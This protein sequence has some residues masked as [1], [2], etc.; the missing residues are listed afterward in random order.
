VAHVESLSEHLMWQAQLTAENEEE[1]FLYES[2]ITSLDPSG[3]YTQEIPDMTGRKSV[4]TDL[5]EQVITK[6]RH[7]DP[8]GCACSNV[9]E[10]LLIQAK[11]YY[12]DDMVM[13]RILSDHFIDLE[14]LN[15]EKIARGIN[16]SVGE[17][18]ETSKMIQNLD[19]FPGRQFR[20]N[21]V[22]YIVPDIDVKYVD[23]EI[24]VAMNDDWIPPIR[25]NSYYV[26]I[27]RKKSIEKNLKDYIQDKLQS[28]K[29]LIK[30]IA[31]RRET[32]IKVVAA[33][34]EA[35]KPFLI[36]GPG[37]L[38]PLTHVEIAEKIGMHESTVSRATTNKFVQTSW[39][40]F[41]LKY[42]FV[43]KLK[44]ANTNEQSSDQVMNLVKNLIDSEDHREPLTD[45]DIVSV[46]KKNGINV[47]R[48]TIS[49]Y[50]S[51]LNIPPSHKRKKI[52]MIKSEGNL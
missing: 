27:L 42:F 3:F 32:I 49:K 18:I 8:V 37:N 15:Y 31:S 33:I 43:S 50:R 34:M 12:P 41:E 52:N 51:V 40:V 48:R 10:S 4:S 6:I 28:A 1:L 38:K 35:Q 13:Q 46:L 23:G 5:F 21:E 26:E 29:Y 39:G 19:P 2:I 47:A 25:I 9:Q 36:K 17:I 45:D 22:R 44:S 24:I 14:N 30:N 20:S 11:Y 7:F 16:K